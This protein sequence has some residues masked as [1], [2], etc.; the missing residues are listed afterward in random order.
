MAVPVRITD[1][2]YMLYSDDVALLPLTLFSQLSYSE[3]PQPAFRSCN[4]ASQLTKSKIRGRNNVKRCT[5]DDVTWNYKV[6]PR[7]F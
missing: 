7:Y 1:S 2:I 4:C 3:Y 5:Y 6:L